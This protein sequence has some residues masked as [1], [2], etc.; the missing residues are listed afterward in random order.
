MRNVLFLSNVGNRDLGKGEESLF[1]PREHNIFEESKKL[2]ESGD[3]YNL[4]PIILKKKIEKLNNPIN[5]L[6][7]VLFATMQ[8]EENPQD[9]YYMAMIIKELLIKDFPNLKDK[10]KIE[11]V[12]RNPSDYGVMIEYYAEKL[13]KFDDE[14]YKI[15]LGITSG[16]PAQING[17]IINGVLKWD[18]KVRTIYKPKRKEPKE[19]EIGG[20]IF[21]ILK[22]KEFEAF[23]ESHLYD[24]AS[25][26]MEKFKLSDN[27]EYEYHYLR[28]LHYKRLFDFEKAKD[29]FNKA[30]DCANLDD[31]EKISKELIILQELSKEPNNLDE[32]IK[33]Y[34]SLIE[35]LIDNAIIK[36]E[37]G[38]Y[39]DFVGRIF[40]IEEAL[41]RTIIE[42]EFNKSM[43]IFNVRDNEKTEKRFLGYEEL[44][45][46]NQD[47]KKYLIKNKID[48]D[49]GVNRHSL[50]SILTYMVKEKK[51]D[52]GKYGVIY[53]FI[54]KLNSK[55][56][57]APKKLEKINSLSDLRNKSII[58]H[59]FMGISK[60]DIIELYNENKNNENEIIDDLKN[61]QRIVKKIM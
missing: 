23:K 51:K 41:P 45:R 43:D 13:N 24:L 22:S 32:E 3:F 18:G 31:E 47:L 60:N 57:N 38:E 36:W 25:E 35:L 6:E 5:N 21:K 48:I 58:A 54:N 50:F 10:I 49:K 26:L 42:K 29:E 14:Y 39:V 59:G 17:L 40:R 12:S 20:K 30:G 11:K 19:N 15:Y 8:E 4:E 1:N 34:A 56:K 9:T 16:A 2:Y 33:K 61:I 46:E 37:N 52:Y 28:A 7:V 27:W 55:P 53:N 44:L